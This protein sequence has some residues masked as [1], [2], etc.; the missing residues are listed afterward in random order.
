[1][2]TNNF[3]NFCFTV[4]FAGMCLCAPDAQAQVAAAPSGDVPASSP[5]SLENQT[6][7]I[8]DRVKEDHFFTLNVENDMFASDQDQ[9]Y[10]SGVRLTYYKLGAELPA[11]ARALDRVVPTFSIN[12]TTSIYY[13]VG[14]NLYTP[15]DITN[16]VQNPKDR[17][18]A[19]FLYGSAG[20]SSVTNNHVDDIEATIGVIGPPALGEQTQKLVHR[21][22]NSPQPQGW[23]NQLH[24]EPGLM[25]SWD[26]R[27]PE[28]YAIDLAG[29][30]ATAEPD[31]G[32]TLGNIYTYANTGVSFRLSPLSGRFQDAPI[33]VRPAMPGTGA[34]LVPSNVFTWYFFGGVQGRAVARNIFL[35]GNTFRDSYS[36]DKKYFVGDATA[37]VAVAYGKIRLSYTTVY[38]TAE[39]EDDDNS[40][41]GSLSLGY[42]F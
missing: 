38:R 5:A 11:F 13:S 4:A 42:R 35:D 9:N 28:H 34:F 31:I 20:L 41:F 15:E 36:V 16:P 7:R 25:L 19:A 39:F 14:Q 32:V 3:R 23:D 1:M 2:T 12:K 26:R 17:P 6:A 8:V 18:W 22:V 37:G 21:I 30:T 29:W 27:W 24:T 33:K 10:S 40:V